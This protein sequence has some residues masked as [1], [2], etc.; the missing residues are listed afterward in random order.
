M[1]HSQTNTL[2]PLLNS[3]PAFAAWEVMQAEGLAVLGLKALSLRST[4][5]PALVRSCWMFLFGLRLGCLATTDPFLTESFSISLFEETKNDMSWSPD[6]LF[7][8]KPKT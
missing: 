2:L 4:F 8:Q 5:N 7:Q 1:A 6:G 3:F